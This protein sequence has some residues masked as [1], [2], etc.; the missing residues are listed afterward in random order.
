[1]KPETVEITVTTMPSGM[2]VGVDSLQGRAPL[3]SLVLLGAKLTINAVPEENG[4][5]FRFWDDNQNVS[6]SR[7]L[8]FN[9][10]GK[11]A[12]HAVYN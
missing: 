1:V 2:T 4:N 8:T 9:T 3:T 7:A 6:E 12:Y 10:A 11:R 5:E